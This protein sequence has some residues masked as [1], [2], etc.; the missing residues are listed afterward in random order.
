METNLFYLDRIRSNKI[1]VADLD[2]KSFAATKAVKES[3]FYW[4]SSIWDQS[5]KIL[6]Y[7]ISFVWGILKVLFFGIE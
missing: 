6:Y 4:T 5:I 1:V 3:I 7:A 2:V